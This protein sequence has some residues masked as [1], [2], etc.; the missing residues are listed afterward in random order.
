MYLCGLLEI[1]ASKRIC[2]AEIVYLAKMIKIQK[3]CLPVNLE[4]HTWKSLIFHKKAK[5]NSVNIYEKK[6]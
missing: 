5:D 2:G 1:Y 4:K 6:L 3:P